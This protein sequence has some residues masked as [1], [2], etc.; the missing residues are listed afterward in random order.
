MRNEE[1]INAVITVFHFHQGQGAH[2]CIYRNVRSTM[3]MTNGINF[4]VNSLLK[5]LFFRRN[6]GPLKIFFSY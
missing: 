6:F 2:S 5:I 1:I 3:N 4:I